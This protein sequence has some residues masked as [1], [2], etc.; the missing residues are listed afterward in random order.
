MEKTKI[1]DC[2]IRDGS[3]AVNFKYTQTDVKNIVSRLVHL[4]I[5]YIEIGHGQGLNASFLLCIRFLQCNLHQNPLLMLKSI[6]M[7]PCL[8]PRI[9]RLV[10][11]AFPELPV[12]KT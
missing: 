1:F 7:Q 2:T 5:E 4:G 6:L 9:A 3:Y 11:S 10:S 8:W 12:W